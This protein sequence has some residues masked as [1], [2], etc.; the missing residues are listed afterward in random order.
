MGYDPWPRKDHCNQQNHKNRQD[1]HNSKRSSF[2]GR[3]AGSRLLAHG[4]TCEICI[5]L[6]CHS[7][8]PDKQIG[9][10]LA[11]YSITSSMNE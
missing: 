11:W 3:I 5:E 6:I 9:C 4:F 1:P 8:D 2:W 10:L 7:I